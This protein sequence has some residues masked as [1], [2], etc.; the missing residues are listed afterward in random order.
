M[1]FDPKR[2]VA[3]QKQKSEKNAQRKKKKKNSNTTKTTFLSSI[4]FPNHGKQ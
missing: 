3:T 2:K 1:K 4:Y